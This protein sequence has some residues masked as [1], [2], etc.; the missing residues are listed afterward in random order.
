[1]HVLMATPGYPPLP[2][3]GERYVRALAVALSQQGQQVTV[4][5]SQARAEADF[6]RG[7]RP[8]ETT[9]LL[10][11]PGLT[12]LACPVRPFPG[13]RSGLLIWRKAMVLLATLPGDWSAVL[14]KMGAWMPR[15]AGYAD[16]LARV[17]TPVDVVHGFNSAW[18]AAL[19]AAWDWAQARRL[20]VVIT[21]FA[22]FGVHWRS[23]VARNSMMDHQRRI[24][25]QAEAV[26]TLTSAEDDGLAAWGVPARRVV[27]VGG[28]LEPGPPP[29]D[30]AA[31]RA[32][33]G[34]AGAYMLFIGRTSF[35]KGAIHAA[36]AVLAARQVGASLDLL[37][38]GQSTP[39]FERF[40]RRL[41]PAEQ[42]HVRPLGIVSETDKHTLLAHCEALLLP[43]RVD[44]F[45]IVLLEA[46]AHGKPV[47]GARAGGVAALVREGV[48]GLL[49]PFGQTPALTEAV[50]CLH[51]QPTLRR[52]L[53]LAGQARVADSLRWSTVAERVLAVY[54]T[55]TTAS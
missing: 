50:L 5:T 18:E 45:G 9:T 20:P 29:G 43:S 39:E 34:L 3:G 17:E 51:D 44:S 35:D 1:M 30:M 40:H 55:L 49:T 32:R 4:V 52:Q 37:L 12:V 10:S 31:L 2:G 47:I 15:L 14:S 53:G 42:T 41:T 48:D 33:W 19:L 22:H 36:Q 8:G 6:W 7:T 21:P 27:C 46:W 26:L 16:A 13:G 23:R 54:T 25:A 28:G 24:L 11:S 38:V